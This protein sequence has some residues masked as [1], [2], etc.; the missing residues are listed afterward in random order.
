MNLSN[1]V[2]SFT[3][4]LSVESFFDIDINYICDKIIKNQYGT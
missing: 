2:Q 1:Q 3:V 4:F